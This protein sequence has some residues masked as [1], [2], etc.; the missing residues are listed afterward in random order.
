[1]I[2][3]VRR[4]LQN[5]EF[6]SLSVNPKDGSER[7][8][9]HSV[10]FA[11]QR[12]RG[13][14]GNLLRRFKVSYVF[15]F[16]LG[17]MT[18]L[19]I[20]ANS[21]AE[22]RGV[23]LS[24]VENRALKNS[25]LIQKHIEGVGETRAKVDS[26]DRDY[27]L[28]L[29]SVYRYNLT[30]T[31]GTQDLPTDFRYRGDIDVE[32]E[33]SKT[34]L[35][36]N[37]STKKSL[38]KMSEARQFELKQ[39]EADELAVVRIFFFNALKEKSLSDGDRSAL[40][41]IEQIFKEVED[42]YK[43]REILYSELMKV[44]HEV[45]KLRSSERQHERDYS[46]FINAIAWRTGISGELR[47]VPPGGVPP[48]LSL[49]Q[50]KGKLDSNYLLRSLKLKQQSVEAEPATST[51]LTLSFFGGYTF[52]ETKDGV[53]QDGIHVGLRFSVPLTIFGKAK[54]VKNEIEHRAKG[55]VYEYQDVRQDINRQVDRL[56]FDFLSDVD[57]LKLEEQNLQLIDEDIRLMEEYLTNPISTIK[58]S[59]LDLLHKRAEKAISQAQIEARKYDLW[60]DYY[61][62]YKF[63]EDIR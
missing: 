12:L 45:E 53:S 32:W 28:Y 8:D 54:A 52:D 27:G 37:T 10:I 43:K 20:M 49:E 31:L 5:K 9:F 3:N 59:N 33:L 62:L 58:F 42:L 35:F 24:E 55:I 47:V 15:G 22:N 48:S 56:S 39:I 21:Y 38:E 40:A 14:G 51:L 18:G 17:A 63:T 46:R 13:W 41:F 16:I 26:L 23:T 44:R 34:G 30:N 7:A 36:G 50:L 6:R 25:P 11:R 1:M 4:Q 19:F 57:L 60:L 2:H 29:R 61:K